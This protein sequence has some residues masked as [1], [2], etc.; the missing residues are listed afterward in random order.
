MQLEYNA[1]TRKLF[2]IQESSRDHPSE[3]R[4]DYFY[5]LTATNQLPYSLLH[6]NFIF[7]LLCN[8]CLRMASDVSW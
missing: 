7:V 3:T 8:F 5:P 2:R 4:V 6:V 1:E